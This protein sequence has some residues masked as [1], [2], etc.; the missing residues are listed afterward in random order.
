M[1]NGTYPLGDRVIE[2]SC[3]SCVGVIRVEYY[4]TSPYFG[5]AWHRDIPKRKSGG[6]RDP[7]QR[8]IAKYNYDCRRPES[9]L[10]P[11]Q[12]ELLTHPRH[13]W[14]ARRKRQSS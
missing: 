11:W 6:L 8:R 5:E 7:S 4:I 1:C 14:W 13:V 12:V 9:Y 3:P 10:E 2:C